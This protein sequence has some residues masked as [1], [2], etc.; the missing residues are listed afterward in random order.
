MY[1]IVSSII[2]FAA[3]SM[4]F[5]QTYEFNASL[6]KTVKVQNHTGK[7]DI[8][9]TAGAATVTVD[10]AKKQNDCDSTVLMA[11]A[12][13]QVKI[14]KKSGMFKDCSAHIKIQIPAAVD[15]VIVSGV[16]DINI[17]GVNGAV[18][19]DLGVGNVTIDGAVTKLNGNLGTGD[20]KASGL[21]G[22]ANLN[23]GTGDFRVTYKEAPQSGSASFQAG[24]GDAVVVLPRNTKFTTKY[25]SA[26]GQLKNKLAVTE[27]AAFSVSFQTAAGDLEIKEL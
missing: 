8:S 6:V 9:A 19:Y 13:L 22:S 23:T 11:G 2:I 1:Q 3:G 24:A 16:G 25:Q 18:R 4:S 15:V 21:V 26:V 12:E 5:A 10:T 7:I 27:D 17:L 20:I 14:E